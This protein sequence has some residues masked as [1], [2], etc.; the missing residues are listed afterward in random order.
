MFVT[1]RASG[2]SS[3]PPQSYPDPKIR[4]RP[5]PEMQ[6]QS[7]ESTLELRARER[8]PDGEIHVWPLALIGTETARASFASLLSEE[9]R[10][11][12]GRYYFERDRKSFV[13]AR[14]QMRHLLAL[15]CGADAASLRFSAGPSGKPELASDQPFARG[16]SFNLTH[17]AGRGILAVSGGR[18]LGVDLESHERKTDVLAIAS[19][20]FF[21]SELAAINSA[22]PEERVAEFFRFWT[23]KEAVIKAQGTGLGAPLDSFRVDLSQPGMSAVETFDVSHIDAGWFLQT[24]PCEAGW[25]AAVVAKGNDWRVELKGQPGVASERSVLA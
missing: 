25:S 17:S 7:P 14:G 8:V 15:Y 12:A 4:M 1:D 5:Y 10:A 21:A 22:A 2:Q 13:F 11:R 18:A 16:I 9:E 20:Y 3:F 6:F 23:A 24:L 19:R